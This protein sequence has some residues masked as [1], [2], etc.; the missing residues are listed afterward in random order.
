M[1]ERPTRQPFCSLICFTISHVTPTNQTSDLRKDGR[2]PGGLV[3][4]P[5][6]RANRLRTAII[7]AAVAAMGF[8]LYRH[9]EV[10]NEPAKPE[11]RP[12][13]PIA[14]SIPTD[15]TLSAN[16]E[17]A[18]SWSEWAKAPAASTPAVAIVNS[19]GHFGSGDPISPLYTR[20]APHRRGS[21]ISNSGSLYT[22][23]GAH[24]PGNERPRYRRSSSC[25]QQ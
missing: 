5:S 3:K 17:S 7:L 12:Y 25:H 4:W 19:Q 14:L 11:S 2:E 23:P 18:S 9:F 24:V 21:D 16:R 6:Y 22:F 8:G 13:M 15:P 20:A 10:A 1:T